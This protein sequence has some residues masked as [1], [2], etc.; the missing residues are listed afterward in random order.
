MSTK[1]VFYLVRSR[2]IIKKKFLSTPPIVVMVFTIVA[3][4]IPS[5]HDR[6]NNINAT[7]IVITIIASYATVRRTRYYFRTGFT[8]KMFYLC[9]TRCGLRPVAVL[10]SLCVCVCPSLLF[11]A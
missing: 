5:G 2:I 7:L 4:P 10:L 11:M 3:I 9:I 1:R 8:L 6:N